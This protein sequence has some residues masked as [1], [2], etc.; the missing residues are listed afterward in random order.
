MDQTGVLLVPGGQDNIYKVKEA[1]QVPIHGKEEKKAFTSIL[2]VDLRGEV[3]P[4][5]F[6]WKGVVAASLPT[7]VASRKATERGHRFALNR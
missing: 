5:Q 3:L 1:K 4:I 2:S 6:V 7:P